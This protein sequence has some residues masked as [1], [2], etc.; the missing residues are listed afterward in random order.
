MSAT[1][2]V[3]VLIH[4]AWHNHSVWDRVTPIL[5]ANGFAALTLDLPGAGVNA[6]APTSL[7]RSPF[8]PAAF[9]AE[10]SPVAGVTQAERTQAVVALVKEAASI[11]DGRVVLVGHSAGGMTISAVAEQVPNLLLAAVYLAGFMVPNG[12]PLLG[13]LQHDSL[14]SALAPRL[15]VGDPAAIGATR[16]KDGS[17][18]EAYRSI[19]KAATYGDVPESAV[20]HAA[21]Q[22]HCDESNAGVVGLET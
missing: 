20:A 19:L 15:F 14:S 17:T 10:R 3:F 13:M 18:N 11:S 7:K 16:I 21:S 4:G 1:K 6:I 9:A 8:D 22:L 2:A 5:K 12:M